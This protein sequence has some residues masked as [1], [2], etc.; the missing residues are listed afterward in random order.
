MTRKL[1]SSKSQQA[2]RRQQQRDRIEEI[3]QRQLAGLLND[4]NWTV[5]P[6]RSILATTSSLTPLM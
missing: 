4:L 2:Q 5:R 3:L 1:L 6:L